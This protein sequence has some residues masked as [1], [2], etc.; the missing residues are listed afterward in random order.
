MSS[1]TEIF[2]SILECI[3]TKSSQI[4][5]APFV[6]VP[7]KTRMHASLKKA[8]KTTTATRITSTST[9][10]QAHIASHACT[11]ASVHDSQV[12]EVVLRNQDAGGGQV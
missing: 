5:D 4:I 10:Q 6:P 9:K 7:I 2:R 11:D 3:D 1:S 12:F 8:G